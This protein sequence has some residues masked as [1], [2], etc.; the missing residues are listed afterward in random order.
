M[1]LENFAFPSN[2]R[3]FYEPELNLCELFMRVIYVFVIKKSSD[4]FLH[5]L[6]HFIDELTYI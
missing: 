3:A 5:I 6:H 1:F 4:A 2:N